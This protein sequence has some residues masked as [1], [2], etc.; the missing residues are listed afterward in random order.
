MANNVGM[1]RQLSIHGMGIVM[2]SRELARPDV[3][4]GKLVPVLGEWSPPALP[5]YA[6]TE[7]RLLPAKVRVFLDFLAAN[8]E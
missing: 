4:T 1:L 5:I 6:L 2:M 3:S 8:L 7:T